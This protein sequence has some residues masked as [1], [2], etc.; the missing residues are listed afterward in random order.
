MATTPD[1]ERTRRGGVLRAA[2][3][4]PRTDLA[5]H[6][7]TAAHKLLVPGTDLSRWLHLTYN[8]IEA[9][10]GIDPHHHEGIDADHAYFVIAGRVHAW[11]DD[12]EFDVGPEELIVFPCSSVHGFRVTSPEGARLLRLGA[13]PDGRTSGGSVFVER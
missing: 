3:V 7:G 1:A 6:P 9:G 2:D 8:V 12:E 4:V 10:G 5:G 13:A 11:I